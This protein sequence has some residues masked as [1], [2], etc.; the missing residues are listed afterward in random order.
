VA[1][2]FSNSGK[3]APEFGALVLITS[4]DGKQW[5]PAKHTLV[6][7]KELHFKDGTQ[8]KLTHLERPFILFN[9][10]GQMQ[11]LMAAASV[12]NPFENK[13][14]RVDPAENTF[15]VQIPLK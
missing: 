13:T 1:K 12:K 11:A 9:K 14:L 4:E 8:T 6:S 5:V 10:K 2:N 3:L 7:L 15:N